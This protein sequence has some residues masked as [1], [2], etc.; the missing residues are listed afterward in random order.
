M[1]HLFAILFMLLAVPAFAGTAYTSSA[2]GNWSA[3]S[4]WNPSG[5]PGNDVTDTVTLSSGTVTLDTSPTI[6]S[7]TSSAGTNSQLL[8]TTTR[9]ITTTGGISYSGTSANGMILVTAGTL[10]LAGPSV[11]NSGS[12]ICIYTKTTGSVVVTGGGVNVSAGQGIHADTGTGIVTISNSGGAALTNSATSGTVYNIYPGSTGTITITGSLS[13][14]GAPLIYNGLATTCRTC[15]IVGNMSMVN[16]TTTALYAWG[17][18]GT[19]SNTFNYTGD[20]TTSSSN[21]YACYGLSVG[22]NYPTTIN[23]KGSLYTADSSATPVYTISQSGS[24]AW[25]GSNTIS[26]GKT[27]IIY[28]YCLNLSNLYMTVPSGSKLLFNNLLGYAQSATYPSVSVTGSNARYIL[29]DSTSYAGARYGLLPGMIVTNGV[30][31]IDRQYVLTGYGGGLL[32]LPP[33][34]FVASGTVYG[35]GPTGNSNTGTMYIGRRQ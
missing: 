22:G 6:A 12:G 31:A 3:A 17:T 34:K 15:S 13:S 8:C 28:A 23:F 19:N 11:S 20:I 21:G 2:T 27:I 1:K 16:S 9:T 29:A 30:Y 10:T 24:F 18:T 14:L 7:L 4:T 26:A 5:V 25:S 33:S 35:S 32:V